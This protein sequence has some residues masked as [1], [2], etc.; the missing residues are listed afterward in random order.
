M[1][2]EEKEKIVLEGLFLGPY[3]ILIKL[4]IKYS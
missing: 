2:Y 1:A 3:Y 4:I